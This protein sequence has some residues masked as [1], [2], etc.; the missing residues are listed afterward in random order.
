[1]Y[2]EKLSDDIGLYQ[3]LG[4]QVFSQFSSKESAQLLLILLQNF[5][6]KRGFSPKNLW[7]IWYKII[8]A[9]KILRQMN[10]VQVLV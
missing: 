9:S 1:M 7:D 10:F 2:S 6:Y 5:F 8:K 4:Y 3:N